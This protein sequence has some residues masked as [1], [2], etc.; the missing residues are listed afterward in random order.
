[1]QNAIKKALEGG[2]SYY[3][4]NSDEQD[5]R[6]RLCL[7][8]LFWQC[9][10]KEEKWDEK[11]QTTERPVY[12]GAWKD[13]WHEFIDHLAEGKDAESFFTQLFLK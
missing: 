13:K 5:T 11:M 12:S 10:G 3:P 2:Y 9:L 1:M 6:C 8:P 7:D 4:K